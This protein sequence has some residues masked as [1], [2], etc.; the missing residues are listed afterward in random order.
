MRH[1]ALATLLFAAL[2]LFAQVELLAPGIISTGDDDAHATFSP[3]GKQVF[4]IKDSPDFAHWTVAV[5]ARN[6]EKLSEPEVAWFSGRYS[7]ADVS[8]DPSGNTMYFIS[9]RPITAGGAPREDTE[10]WRMHRTANGWS[11][12]E[13][14]PELSSE[15]SEWYPNMTADGWLYF[16]SERAEGNLGKAGTS[17]FWRAR[18]VDGHFTKPE[19]LGTHFNTPRN[20]IEPW[21]SAD[22]NLMIFSAGGRPDSAGAYDLYASRRC[23]EQWTAPFHLGGGINSPGWE[24]GARPTPDGKWLV[25]TSNR[26]NSGDPYTRPLKYRELLEKIRSAGNGLRDVYRVP[27]KDI[28]FGPPCGVR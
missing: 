9:T 20:E 27:F 15:G 5:C 17:D 23:G 14:I 18:L 2:P 22:G 12:P 11:E 28:D 19:N 25:F 7:D 6:G 3:D 8:F 10:I 24:F 21:I 1:A 16:G 13:H 4:F 26:T